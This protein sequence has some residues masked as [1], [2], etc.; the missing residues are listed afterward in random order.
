MIS[1]IFIRR[2]CERD[3]IE[4]LI[5][6]SILLLYTFIFTTQLAY[7]QAQDS[8]NADSVTLKNQLV[9]YPI[10]FF[11]PET[12]W[13]LGG[14]G[15]FTFRF[16]NESLTSN[17]SQFQFLAAYTLNKQVLLAFPFEFY[18]KNNLWKIK[19]EM[20]YYKY[21]YN[22]YGLGINSQ[23]NDREKFTISYPRFRIDV[24]KRIGSAFIGLRYRMDNHN[25]LDRGDLLGSGN[26]TGSDGGLY[27][28]LGFIYQWDT[29]D[30][31]YSPSKG[32]FVQLETF[33]NSKYLGSDFDY[34]RYS[35]DAAKYFNVGSKNIWALNL[36]LGTMHGNVPFYD[37]MYFGRPT[38]MRGYQDRRFIDKNMVILQSEYRFPLYKRLQGVGFVATGTVGSQFKE[39]F[40]HP[41]KLTYGM[42]LRF[43]VNKKDQ[44]RL[45]L[46][47][48]FTVNEGGAFYLTSNEAF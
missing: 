3:L 32:S 11:L 48:G 18:I 6:Q 10:V 22:F 4:K 8:V 7:G 23:F 13:G 30:V 21:V 12:N 34:Q 9:S 39:I 19:G 38:Q 31:L 29:R 44:V 1:S 45:R 47:Y 5:F 35:L 27:S 15:I 43:V 37:M 28:G 17:P 36:V 20:A 26:Y 41:Y 46:D 24:Q 33:F 2:L 42:G 40:S 14:A 16:K 25:L